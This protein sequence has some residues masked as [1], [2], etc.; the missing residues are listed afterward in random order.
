ME[1]IGKREY[2]KNPEQYNDELNQQ[3][4]KLN[5]YIMEQI[6]DFEHSKI[7]YNQTKF[8]RLKDVSYGHDGL[9][10]VTHLLFKKYPLLKR[11]VIDKFDYIFIDEFQDSDP[12]IVEDFINISTESVQGNKLTIGLF[13]DSM[14]SIYNDGVGDVERYI[15]KQYLTPVPKADNYRCAYEIVD[16]INTLRL[17]TIQQEVALAEIKPNE[18]EQESDRH[19]TV[20]ILYSTRDKHPD[21]GEDQSLHLAHIENLVNEAKKLAPDAKTLLLTNKAIAA[22]EGF[23]SLYKIF[24]DRYSEVHD[25]IENYLE[26]IQALDICEICYNYQKKQYNDV[27][28]KIQLGGYTI[29]SI[30]SKK[31]LKAIIVKLFTDT[32]F[33][34]TE[35]IDYCVQNQLIKLSNIHQEHKEYKDKLLKDLIQDQEYQQF[36]AF[37][38]EGK[39]TYNRIKDMFPLECEEEFEEYQSRYKKEQFLRALHSKTLMFSE[40]LNYYQYLNEE[41]GH[42]TMHKTKGSSI[43]S[44]IVVMEN[45][46]WNQYDFTSLYSSNVANEK[47]KQ[48]SQKLIYVACSR[49]R[50]NLILVKAITQ[51]EEE[52]FKR[53][54]TAATKILYES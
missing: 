19:G 33:S 21:R 12:H 41:A 39:N 50:K 40:I 4:K 52:A 15:N 30:E 16:F 53:T 36:K 8:D 31:Q 6:N 7:R 42:I 25:Q 22:K 29:N 35:A 3:I 13:G 47:R 51:D 23:V 34:L 46:N 49:A 10:K 45:Y 17:D 24:S 32:N 27:I 38:E 9:L 28:K 26:K 20:E 2:D 14:Q 43:D 1:V 54:F 44:V 48:E 5:E 37:Y 11:I 18:Y